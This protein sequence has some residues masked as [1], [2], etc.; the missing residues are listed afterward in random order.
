MKNV[1]KEQVDG[2]IY[3]YKRDE[4]DRLVLCGIDCQKSTTVLIPKNSK[5]GSRI[6]VL[7]L[8]TVL[9]SEKTEKLIINFTG[10]I[11]DFNCDNE[12]GKFSELT[13]FLVPDS[14]YKYFS[15]DG[16]LYD[17]GNCLTAYP[18]NKQNISFEVPEFAKTI[19]QYA[20]HNA[21]HLID[22]DLSGLGL[23]DGIFSGCQSLCNVENYSLSEYCFEYDD[24]NNAIPQYAFCNTAITQFHLP[25]ECD[26]ILQGAFKGCRKLN[27]IYIG[28]NVRLIGDNAFGSC[29]NLEGFQIAKN[30]KCFYAKDGVLFSTPLAVNSDYR[31]FSNDSCLIVYPSGKKDLEYE[32]PSDC[33]TVETFA[34]LNNEY[35]K[36]LKTKD[37]LELKHF[38]IVNCKSLEE[39]HLAKNII[40]REKFFSKLPIITDC[41]KLK[42]IY[43]SKA[44]NPSLFDHLYDK[45]PNMN[46]KGFHFFLQEDESGVY[47]STLENLKKKITTR[48]IDIKDE[49]LRLIPI[50]VPETF[51]VPDGV[52]TISP[53]S[54]L[55]VSCNEIILPSS[56]KTI[57]DY[58]FFNCTVDKL[59]APNSNIEK[60]G[61]KA[62]RYSSIEEV[63]IDNSGVAVFE[64]GPEAFANCQWLKFFYSS[65]KTVL[66]KPKAFSNCSDLMIFR[67][68]PNFYIQK[69]D[70]F[71]G[72]DKII[73]SDYFNNTPDRDSPENRRIPFELSVLGKGSSIYL[74]SLNNSSKKQRA[75]RRI[76]ISSG[77]K[78]IA[79]NAISGF[80]KVEE[81]VIP[82]SV[83][84]IE[85]SAISSCPNLR[86]IIIL[87]GVK[88]MKGI[89][90]EQCPKL[91]YIFIPSTVSDIDLDGYLKRKVTPI[92]N[93]ES[94]LSDIDGCLKTTAYLKDVK[95]ER[96]KEEQL[97]ATPVT[98]PSSAVTIVVQKFKCIHEEH[99][100][101][102][103]VANISVWQDGKINYVQAP[104]GYCENC[105]QYYI[106]S[107]TFKRLFSEYLK[108]DSLVSV[109]N[110]DDNLVG[111]YFG[112]SFNNSSILS[113]YG[114]AVGVTRGLPESMRMDILK[115]ILKDKAATKEELKSYLNFFI[116]FNGQ[117]SGMEFAVEDWENDLEKI[118]NL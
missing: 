66:L 68:G 67:G 82:G 113:E 38:S 31:F 18:C 70:V 46:D 107:E 56:I 62:F 54:F 16:I 94:L 47:F 96:E 65:S 64:I 74:E 80:P 109:F 101:R 21:K 93:S 86:R 59:I 84:T 57:S 6:E 114:Y 115:Q 10:T 14:N 79:R 4:M 33:F 11:G 60:I 91:E 105:D 29:Y 92:I 27:T 23:S 24:I 26:G 40:S 117:K 44:Q 102:S 104:V 90:F 112:N 7:E 75:K 108:N 89:C 9:N 36:K 19:G 3:F 51:K 53:F 30:N 1:V 39:V 78:I 2:V 103:L 17:S 55:G 32:I 45:C 43:L 76:N 42:M 25:E 77:I 41:S 73:Y 72:A 98:I 20:F 81:I 85:E 37:V 35:L 52:T 34:F 97:E 12:F 100:L 106:Y 71:T 28:E 118:D 88:V 15:V 58:A 61:E 13:E 8:E 50:S 110:Y 5:D 22:V 63:S 83:D 99:N 48:E 116:T 87:E 49:S 69:N 111:W 95:Y